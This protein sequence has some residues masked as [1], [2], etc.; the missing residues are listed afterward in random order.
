MALHCLFHHSSPPARWHCFPTLSSLPFWLAAASLP[1]CLAHAQDFRN[2]ALNAARMSELLAA[3]EFAQ[4]DLVI[5]QPI[6]DL[7]TRRVLVME[8]VTGVKLTTLAPGEIR[9]LIKVGQ[10]A[11]LTQLLEIGEHGLLVIAQG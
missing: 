4:A 2:E 3:S 9:A 11:F 10:E 1:W 6:M 7:T 8:W 5:P